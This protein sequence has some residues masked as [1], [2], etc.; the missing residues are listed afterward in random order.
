MH[1][2]AH[3]GASH[4]YPENTTA[5]YDAAL[6]EG[7]DGIELDLQL[8]SDGVPVIFHDDRLGKLGHPRKRIRDFTLAQLQTMDTGRW[9]GA[10]PA[11]LL[12]LDEVLEAYA[13]KT[14][15][16]LEIKHTERRAIR[17]RDLAEATARSIAR[18]HRPDG[19]FVLSFHWKALACIAQL[20]PQ[21]GCVRNLDNRFGAPMLRRYLVQLAGVCI[22]IDRFDSRH[23]AMLE[24][25]N[26]PLYSYTCD[27]PEQ[28]QRAQQLG[29]GSVITNQPARSRAW[30][31][32][33]GR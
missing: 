18:H 7:A 23:K 10:V 26:K 4:A 31:Q 2:I 8:S 3:R 30:F 22:N 6:Q 32:H 33:G 20:Q 27:T 28:L 21:V 14:R 17:H 25:L 5:A 11:R 1:I 12:T 16:Y 29:V 24:R 19:L 15:L 9:F 13:R